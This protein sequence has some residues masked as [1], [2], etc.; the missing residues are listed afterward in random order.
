MPY[1][2]SA[3]GYCSNVHRGETLAAV[4]G[5]LQRYIDA[6][7][8]QRSLPQMN[9]GLW[10]A[11]QAADELNA[12]PDAMQRFCQTLDQCN[13]DLVTLN[14]FPFGN[15][16][17][18]QVKAA[19]YQ[20]DWRHASR[21]DYTLKLASILAAC[22]PEDVAEGTIST[23]PLGDSLC[24][25]EL[26][27]QQAVENLLRM[28]QA[29]AQLYDET[30]KQIRLCLEMEPG[31]VL[32]RSDQLIDFFVNALEQGRQ[33]L[34]FPRGW[35]DDHLGI[36]F[37]VCHQAVM[38]EEVAASLSQIVDAGIAVGKI[39]LS[40]ALHVPSPHLPQ[41]LEALTAFDEPRYLH[42][43]RTLNEAGELTG[44]MDLLAA[45][46]GG[47]STCHPWRIHFHLPLQQATIANGLLQTTHDA[48]GEVLDFIAATPGFRP[49]LEVETYT[50]QVLPKALG[51]ES[52]QA[53]IDGIVGEL[54]W[55]EAQ[56]ATRGLLA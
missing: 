44:V 30:G 21:Y 3:L 20:P 49:H 7:R 32:E 18:P 17:Q 25:T 23:V 50:W 36:C 33:C 6:V 12:S 51:A 56:M 10:L 9:S 1:P 8:Q 45:L 40:S 42:Q 11:S 16:H 47:L 26:Q 5:N 34:G 24:W 55:V 53:L 31:C 38:F 13:I 37:D 41:T 43:V 27:Q 4:N 52:D 22:L 19:V 2:R 48:V 46:D 15:F 39:Q 14:G 28:S 35:I 54:N 29:L